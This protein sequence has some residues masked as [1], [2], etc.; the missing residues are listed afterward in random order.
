MRDQDRLVVRLT[1]ADR[2]DLDRLRG[3]VG[4]GPFLRSLLRRA[5]AE[6]HGGGPDDALISLASLD[7]HDVRVGRVLREIEMKERLERLRVLAG[8]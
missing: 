6:A 5:V 4:R 8:D 2:R 1:A 7:E 3:S